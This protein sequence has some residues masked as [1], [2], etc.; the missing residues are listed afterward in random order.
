MLSRKSMAQSACTIYHSLIPLSSTQ[1]RKGEFRVYGVAAV[2]A[3][4]GES[5]QSHRYVM[6]CTVKSEG[7]ANVQTHF[8]P[9]KLTLIHNL[10]V[11]KI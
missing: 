11:Q 4:G 5:R 7:N 10:A 6:F 9:K 3:P 8:F 1:T 2:A